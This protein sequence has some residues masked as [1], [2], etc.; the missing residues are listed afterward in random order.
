MMSWPLNLFQ[1]MLRKNRP[2]ENPCLP[3]DRPRGWDLPLHMTGRIPSEQDR[4]Q[5]V[6]DKASL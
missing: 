6:L 3:A 1:N 4:E 2:T 5:T